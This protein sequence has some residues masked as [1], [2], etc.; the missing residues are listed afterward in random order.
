M[1]LAKKPLLLLSIILVS[2]SLS[3]PAKD[4]L[5]TPSLP[6][7][8]Y[9]LLFFGSLAVFIINS[10]DRPSS[11]FQWITL[12]TSM[13]SFITVPLVYARQYSCTTKSL[14]TTMAGSF[15]VKM[16]I[17]LKGC[18][19]SPKTVTTFW[20][21]LM[22][23]RTI[24]PSDKDQQRKLPK[25]V[26]LEE[27]FISFIT[28]WAIYVLCVEIL[29]L[30]PPEVPSKP[31]PLR[32]IDFIRTGKPFI[33]LHA[34][35]YCYFYGGTLA[36]SMSFLYELI[37]LHAAILFR[38]LSMKPNTPLH[39]LLTPSQQESLKEWLSSLLFHAK[40]L[41][42][43]PI[44]SSSPIDF[45]KNRWH[46]ACTESFSNLGG[47]FARRF[48]KGTRIRKM[49]EVVGTF[50]VSAVVHEYY[51]N[52]V[53]GKSKG[54]HF[55]FILFHALILIVWE[56]VWG[57][58]RHLGV[59]ERKGHNIEDEKKGREDKGAEK[60]MLKQVAKILVWNLISLFTAPWFFERYI[61][62]EYYHCMVHLVCVKDTVVSAS[63]Y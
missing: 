6:E 18:L 3:V 37:L 47:I 10:Y 33:S 1:E 15:G 30:F 42:N 8:V 45:W 38:V 25:S 39:A 20:W 21:S 53:H 26:S 55:S 34:L 36:I 27:R 17:W 5:P 14:T 31:Y 54:E 24:K 32:V 41:F 2:I 57:M 22:N 23:W 4:S 48:R 52:A 62:D 19:E 51:S 35:L 44:L 58:W 56:N 61:R 9:N 50:F 29:E 11:L 12:L 49:M 63:A 7:P 13:I 59:G 60:K 16:L 46:S 43:H 28:V 40:P